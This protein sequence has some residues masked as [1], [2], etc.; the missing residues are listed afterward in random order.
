MRYLETRDNFERALMQKLAEELIEIR[1][2]MDLN[3]AT[4]IAN[5]VGKLFKA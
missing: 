2:I 3:L 5:Q 1:K 4:A